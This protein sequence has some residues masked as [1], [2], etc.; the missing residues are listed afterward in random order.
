MKQRIEIFGERDQA[1]KRD[2]VIDS[3]R[4]LL[5]V[6]MFLHHLLMSSFAG[7]WR[8][9]R[10]ISYPFGWVPGA[11][12]FVFVSGFVIGMRYGFLL[13]RR[14]AGALGA[15]SRQ[16]ALPIYLTHLG[17]LMVVTM[18]I[19]VWPEMVAGRPG[20]MPLAA[21]PLREVVL[22][23]TLLYQPDF[24]D[25]LPMYCLYLLV[26]PLLLTEFQKGRALVWLALSAGLWGA[27][28]WGWDPW[29]RDV[30][31]QVRGASLGLFNP[32]GWQAV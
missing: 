6:Y 23:A 5:V 30:I 3:L 32:L 2:P 25:I 16:Q 1:M 11:A 31:G 29:L 8:L 17:T 22:G 26:T 9:G 27:A 10:A 21:A 4:G 12:G 13:Q 20:L 15:A 14:G 24:F 7:L 18:G 19:Q 28:Q